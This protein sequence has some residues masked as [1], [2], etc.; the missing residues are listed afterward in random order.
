MRT[1]REQSAGEDRM[2]QVFEE[3]FRESS[4]LKISFEDAARYNRNFKLTHE[5]TVRDIDALVS[6]ARILELGAFTGV[7]AVTLARLGHKVTASDHPSILQD[8]AASEFLRRNGVDLCPM[9]LADITF[10]LAD[11]SFDV[12]DFHSILSL[13]NFNPIPLLKEFHRL[14]ATGGYV[15]CAAPNLLAA[16][17]VALMVLRRGY[18]SP[19]KHFEW[20]LEEASEGTGLRVGLSWREY[21]E[22]EVVELFAA[23]GF[24]LVTHK[25]G[26]NTPNRSSFPR[27]QLVD[28]LYGLFPSLMPTQIGVFRK[29]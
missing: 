17:N 7:V 15:Y 22:E 26:L 2:Q 13:L 20:N 28:A 4:A 1:N 9:N 6:G 21:S 24:D 18:L 29:R 14:L 19:I 23:S 3:V 5:R 27:R 10:P 16:K 25:F 8:P 12:V 11:G